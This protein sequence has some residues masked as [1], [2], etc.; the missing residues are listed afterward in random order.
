MRPQPYALRFVHDIGNSVISVAC[1]PNFSLIVAGAVDRHVYGLDQDGNKIW[2]RRLDQEV[3]CTS[4]SAD[5][6]RS[7]AGTANKKPAS[8]TV[9]V[10]DGRGKIVFQE[11]IGAPVWDVSLSADGTVL[12]ASGWDGRIYLY[13]EDAGLW[14]R[15]G[16]KEISAA[17]TYGVT[18]SDNADMIAA[19]SY[20]D[21]LVFFTPELEKIGEI[22]DADFGYRARIAPTTGM[23]ITGMRNGSVNLIERKGRKK[24]RSQKLSQRPICGVAITPS[25]KLCIAGGFDGQFHALTGDLDVLWSYRTQ[26][27]VWAIDVSHDGRFVCV[28]SGDGKIYALENHVTDSA[29]DEIACLDKAIGRAKTFE[30]KSPLVDL[31]A[32][33]Y[34]KYGLLQYGLDRIDRLR[35]EGKIESGL[36]VPASV[37]L[38]KEALRVNP[39]NFNASYALARHY[40]RTNDLWNAALAYTNASNDASLRQRA[41]L[42]AAR[43]FE[44]AG[45]RAAA[46]SCFRRAREQSLHEDD[47]R[48]LYNLARSL[49]DV[50]N[51]QEARLY[52]DILLTWDPAYRDA[53]RRSLAIDQG[54]HHASSAGRREVDYTGLTVNLM[55]P[56][57][58]R[59]GDVDA[60]LHAVVRA[61]SKELHV[62]EDQRRQYKKVLKKFYSGNNGVRALTRTDLEY[63]V[64]SYIKYDFLLPEDEIKKELERVNTLTLLEGEDIRRSLDIGAATGRWPRT[65]AS[66]GI[67]AF[68][69]DIEARAIAYAKQKLSDDEVKRGNPTLSVGN[70]LSLA[71]DDEEFC[72]VTC[73]MGTFAHIKKDDHTKF[74]GEVGRV[75]R[76]GGF[77]LVS[78]WDIECRHQAYLSMYTLDEKQMIDDNSL[79]QKQ[80]LCSAEAAGFAPRDLVP[81]CLVPDVVSFEL[82]I[83]ELHA[84]SLSQM[85]SIDLAAR[86]TFPEMHGQM[87]LA[88]MQRPP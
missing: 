1:T 34:L 88:L 56:E 78:T 51:F 26:G 35:R 13:E 42:A 39:R 2:S 21:K 29:L 38:L 58:P 19:V 79:T 32:G 63:N 4:V 25:A 44:R 60:S 22:A 18:I 11:S 82:G 75:L 15:R 77:L 66:Q 55:T 6:S 49:E 12:V 30:E 54:E 43:C 10:L 27:E 74:F 69:V 53:A 16:D 84:D 37:G 76:P 73:M 57:S 41:F 70:G 85:L 7:A 48:I 28:A 24:Q 50:K 68:G 80:F 40:E 72:L 45:H 36:A 52:Y 46:G 83:K 23:V 14:K 64:Q 65:F 33:Y 31:L 3:W 87:Y 47:L 20:A 61:R 71:F 62:S 9:F 8:G 81:I 67:Q 86:S 17:G 5:G 59:Y